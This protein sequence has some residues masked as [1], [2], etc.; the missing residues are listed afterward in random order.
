MSGKKHH[1]YP[2]LNVLVC[3]SEVKKCKKKGFNKLSLA[4]DSLNQPSKQTKL[5]MN[6]SHSGFRW[7]VFYERSF[8]VYAIIPGS[9]DTIT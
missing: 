8:E 1:H 6:T 9:H 3:I 7:S 2:I 5:H 4:A